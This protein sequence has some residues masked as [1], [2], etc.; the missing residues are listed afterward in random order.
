MPAK[1]T[2][3]QPQTH[4]TTLTQAKAAPAPVAPPSPLQQRIDAFLRTPLAFV[5]VSVVALLPCYWGSYIQAG[6]LASHI[7]NSWLAQ[8]VE[9]QRLQGLTVVNQAT[10][11]LFDLLLGGLFRTLGADLAQ[12]IAVGLAALTFIWGAFA[13]ASRAS[14]KRAW[15]V[16]PLIIMLAYGWTF[17]MGFFDFYLSLGLSFWALAAAWDPTPKRLAMAA[18]FLILAFLAHALAFAWGAAFVAYLVAAKYLGQARWTQLTLAGLA[19]IGVVRIAISSL[20]PSLWVGQQITLITGADQARIFDD[21][22]IILFLGLLAVWA[23]LLWQTLRDRAAGP[24]VRRL[25]F[26]LTALS[27]AGVLLL[28]DVI[29]IPG[30]R[31]SLVYIAERMSLGVGICL[32]AALAQSKFGKPQRWAI[33]AVT[34]AF[35]LFL[36]LDEHALNAFE[37]R[38]AQTLAG[39][40]ANHRVLLGL[41]DP[42]MTR[43]NAMTHMID[44]E[45]IGR[46]YSYANYEPST[47]QFRVRA[48]APNPY[49]ASEYRDSFA[50]QTGQYMVR[51]R[52]LPLI[53][54]SID[55]TG[56][57]IL[58]SL[59]AGAPNGVRLCKVLNGFL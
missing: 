45:C 20:W 37:K 25:P 4:R 47:W 13:F 19:A 12:R 44:R 46:C 27:A 26:H 2:R 39:M 50:M 30:Y 15:S 31:H 10:N 55:S 59:P 36:F 42:G 5:V 34:A 53:E 54:V 40:P 38:L 35:F 49:V 3:P 6:D 51:D 9:T 14:G 48:V 18:P 29:Q 52:D 32:C 57:L 21:K 23:M 41:D 58:L 8:L 24:L 56:N 17:H 33:G 22:Y 16:L 11:V 1:R 28:P 7:Y 43:V